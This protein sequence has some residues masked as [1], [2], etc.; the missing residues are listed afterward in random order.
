M[1][2]WMGGWVVGERGGGCKVLVRSEVRT[3]VVGS[4]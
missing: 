4:E 1:D 2:G 3:M